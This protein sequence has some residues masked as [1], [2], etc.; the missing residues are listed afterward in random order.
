MFNPP[1]RFKF[2]DKLKL[3]KDYLDK[4]SIYRDKYWKEYEIILLWAA[5]PYHKHL[6]TYLNSDRISRI[7]GIYKPYFKL[8]TEVSG[9]GSQNIIDSLEQE[10][11]SNEVVKLNGKNSELAEK[12]TGE[13]PGYFK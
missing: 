4:S 11:L 12:N 5:S 8:L 9:R 2:W 7:F 13:F 3:Y 10:R 1:I 6:G